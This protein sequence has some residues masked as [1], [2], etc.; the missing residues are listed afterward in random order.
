M[1]CYCCKNT[2]N[3]VC[4]INNVRYFICNNC[5]KSLNMAVS[6]VKKSK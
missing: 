6:T 4:K 5:K 1:K 3:N 2:A